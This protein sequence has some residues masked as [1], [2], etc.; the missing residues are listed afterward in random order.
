MVLQ[1]IYAS[2][3]LSLYRAP[4]VL[5]M[6]AGARRVKAVGE[7]RIVQ[8]LRPIPNAVLL[9]AEVQTRDF[10]VRPLHLHV[11]LL[12]RRRRFQRSPGRRRA[13]G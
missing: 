9:H 2:T 8:N 10:G 11:K 3:R 13:G 12:A 5:Q 1:S 6:H 4:L 7:R